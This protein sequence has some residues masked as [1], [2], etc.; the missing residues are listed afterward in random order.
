MDTDNGYVLK[1]ARVIRDTCIKYKRGGICVFSSLLLKDI[2][3]GYDVKTVQGYMCRGGKY[4]WHVW[5]EYNGKR[6]DI[7]SDIVRILVHRTVPIETEYYYE[8]PHGVTPQHLLDSDE[9]A[10]H[11]ITAAMYEK[12]KD[13][14]NIEEYFASAPQIVKTIR[15][16]VLERVRLDMLDAVDVWDLIGK[17]EKDI[18]LEC[19]GAGLIK[20][21]STFASILLYT[22][23][24]S[25]GIDMKI[26]ADGCKIDSR[27]TAM[28]HVWCEYLGVII[29][30]SKEIYEMGMDIIRIL[31]GTF[32]EFSDQKMQYLHRKNG[33]IAPYKVIDE[34][35]R[36][37]AI[38]AVSD[39]DTYWRN[40]PSLLRI[41]KQMIMDNSKMHYLEAHHSA[42]LNSMS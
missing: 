25:L 35:M 12:Y 15:S 34:S 7:G 21:S 31:D 20:G 17:I 13:A 14:D 38:E 27:G 22:V 39:I 32:I 24:R 11:K 4:I 23:C 8:L 40:A 42:L 30:P 26:V 9:A 3:K 6:I 41:I 36:N 19:V 10:E 28:S 2:C 5:C 33:S 1:V 29:D 16:E 18:I 37:A